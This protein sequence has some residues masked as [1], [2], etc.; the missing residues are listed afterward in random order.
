MKISELEGN[1]LYP[2]R[3]DEQTSGSDSISKYKMHQSVTSLTKFMTTKV[4]LTFGVIKQVMVT[5]NDPLTFRGHTV[6]QGDL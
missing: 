2:I 3:T 5:S 6:G 1:F 4:T